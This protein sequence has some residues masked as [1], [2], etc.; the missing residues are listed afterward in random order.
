MNN[1]RRMYHYR[2]QDVSDSVFQDIAQVYMNPT[3]HLSTIFRYGASRS[4]LEYS[5]HTIEITS[6]SARIKPASR[7]SLRQLPA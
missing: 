3:D 1:L 7:L 5:K 2:M 6:R 4:P